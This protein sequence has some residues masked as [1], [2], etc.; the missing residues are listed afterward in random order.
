MSPRIRTKFM[1]A[2]PP[3]SIPALEIWRG[4]FGINDEKKRDR[5]N[6][7]TRLKRKLLN[8]VSLSANVLDGF[9]KNITAP[10]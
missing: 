2:T 9:V 10:K 3:V 5:G 8:D 4:V 1:P 7:E 6:N